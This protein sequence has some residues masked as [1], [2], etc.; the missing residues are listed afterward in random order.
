L[1]L[2]NAL[3]VLDLG[4]DTLNGLGGLEIKDENLAGD[5]L[6]GDLHACKT[7]K[8]KTKMGTY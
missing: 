4:K 7:S 3:V 5:G 8:D 1:V 6:H 2:R